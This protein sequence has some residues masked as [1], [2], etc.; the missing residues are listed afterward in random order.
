MRRILSIVDDMGLWALTVVLAVGLVLAVVAPAVA[1][2]SSQPIKVVEL[3]HAVTVT[4]SGNVTSAAVDLNRV[5]NGGFFS[6]QYAVTATGA[7]TLK[8]EYLLSND[9]TNFLEPSSAS[10]IATGVTKASGPGSDGKDVVS[11]A[12][13]PARW[14]KIKVTESAAADAT[15]TLWLFVQ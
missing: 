15:L 10:D 4:G 12:P 14:M 13:E 6:I 5:A 11:F 2:D 8:F 3:F 9:G 1:G 7:P